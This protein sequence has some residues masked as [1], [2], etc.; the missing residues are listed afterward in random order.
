MTLGELEQTL[1]IVIETTIYLPNPVIM[2]SPEA[3]ARL[4]ALAERLQQIENV[5]Q[6]MLLDVANK[7]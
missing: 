2:A 4:V 7:S 5:K 3:Y 1:G 6:S